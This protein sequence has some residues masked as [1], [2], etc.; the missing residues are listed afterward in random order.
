MRYL[1]AVL[2][3]AAL[4]AGCG[5]SEEKKTSGSDAPG[6]IGDAKSSGSDDGSGSFLLGTLAKQLTSSL[7]SGE[8][9]EI[10][11]N[12]LR[13]KVAKA[14]DESYSYGQCQIATTARDG[15]GETAPIYLVYTD[16]DLDCDKDAE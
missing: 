7:D 10:K 6:S 15:I 13:I 1:V 4:L 5:S 14:F 12:T 11:D 9:F 2:V 8:S 16:R 3:S